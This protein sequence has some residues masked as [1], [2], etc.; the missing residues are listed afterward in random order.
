MSTAPAS[1][2]SPDRTAPAAP[3]RARTMCPMNCH[4]TLCGMQVE[5]RDERLVSVAGDPDNP[6]SAGF[7]CVRGHASRE[8]YDHPD[9]LLHPLVRDSRDAPFRRASWD[10]ALARIAA[11]IAAGPPASTAL[12]PGHGT[13]TTNYGTRINAQLMARFANFLGGQFWSPT[14]VCW[15]L[16]A[17]GLALTGLLETSTKEDLGDHAEAV[18]LWGANLPSQ[19]NTARFLMQAK[20]RGAYVAAIDVRRTEAMA[21]AD[22]AFVIR[23]GTD[24]ALALAMLQVI[25]AEDLH[26]RAF[27]DAHT[28]GFDALAAHLRQY[29][30]AWAEAITGVPAERIAA[31]ARRYATTRPAMIVLGGSSMHKGDNGWMASRAVACLPGVTGQVGVPGSGFGPRHGSASH[32]RGL[33][34]IVAPE[35]RAPGTAMPNQMSA[36]L[37]AI[38]AGRIGTLLLLG[39]NMLSSFADTGALERGL[40]RTRC[41]VSYDLFM[42]E[43]ARRFADV[44]LP[45]TAWLEELGA[46]ATAT[47]LYLMPKVLPPA[48]ECRTVYQLLGA[49]AER[50]GLD[51]YDPWRSDEAMVDAVLDHPATGHATVAALRAEDGIRAMKVSHVA[52]PTRRFD[53]PSGRI[54]FE[55]AQAARLGLPALPTWLGPDPGA[56]T[57]DGAYPLV[58]THGRTIQHFHGFYDHGRALPSL[59]RLEAGPRLWLSPADAAARGVA[60]GAPI[61]VRSAQG[62][63]DAHALVT[64]RVP[65]GTVWMRDG[66][67]GLNRLT[68]SRAVLPDAAVDVFAFSAGQSTFAARVEVT[69]IG[70]AQGVGGGDADAAA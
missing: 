64:D 13:F 23:P 39:T 34:S 6:D 17:F 28:L 56:A 62:T 69:A 29:T 49:L 55:S 52:Y 32:G 11:S 1:A 36:V 43:T 15:G 46:K 2:T 27:V 40:A 65:P 25:V 4:P 41:V 9:R 8:I 44:V 63:M 3:L 47:H 5:V 26:D 12:W 22:D 21:K 35:R 24:T 59:A 60:D 14:M 30:P 67:P 33:G 70:P 42:H 19:P 16:G 50:L 53:T 45:S 61:R 57:G 66:W 20:A 68:E 58:L 48:G 31:L 38:E 18:L 7:L 37:E 10:E 51:G 54:E